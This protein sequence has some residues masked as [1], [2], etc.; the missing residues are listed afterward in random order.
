MIYGRTVCLQKDDHSKIFKWSNR[1]ETLGNDFLEDFIDRKLFIFWIGPV[2]VELP[3]VE[4]R[5]PRDHFD[6]KM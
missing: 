5:W 4:K 2:V 6:I 3:A 1:N